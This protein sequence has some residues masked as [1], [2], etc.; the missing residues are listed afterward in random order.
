M[1]PRDTHPGPARPTP[2]TPRT[3]PPATPPPTPPTDSATDAHAHAAPARAPMP[4][5]RRGLSVVPAR[6]IPII[7]IMEQRGGGGSWAS[8]RTGTGACN[9]SPSSSRSASRTC[10]AGSS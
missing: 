9:W 6:V 3:T 4:P 2:T 7:G 8:S 10:R 5:R 1:P